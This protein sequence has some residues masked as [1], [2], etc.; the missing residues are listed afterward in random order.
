MASDLRLAQLEVFIV[1]SRYFLTFR[2]IRMREHMYLGLTHSNSDGKLVSLPSIGAS[3][4]S[5]S[6]DMIKSANS[7]MTS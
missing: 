6:A 4:P 1:C 2:N 3:V 5:I 7:G